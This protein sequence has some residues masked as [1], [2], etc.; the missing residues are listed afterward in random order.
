MNISEHV[1]E[2]KFKNG[3]YDC[4]TGNADFYHFLGKKRLYTSFDGLIT[5]TSLAVLEKVVAKRFYQKPFI[6]EVCNEDGTTGVMVCR[7]SEPKEPGCTLIRMKELD[8]IFEDYLTAKMRQREAD[9]LL[10]LHDCIYYSYD[11]LTDT[12]ICY[13]CD[14]ERE[15]L[16]SLKLDQWLKKAAARL[17]KISHGEVRKFADALIGGTRNFTGSFSV[18]AKSSVIF[19]GAAIYDD[20]IHIKTVGAFEDSN[21]AP[22]HKS[23]HKDQLT[24]LF[25]KED[26]NNYAKRLIGDLK[27]STTLAI[28]DIDDFKYVNDHHGH[29][30]G[31]AVLKKC[32]SIIENE[33]GAY[34][35]AGRIGGDEFLVVFDKIPDNETLRYVLRAIKNNIASAYSDEKDGFHVTTSIGASTYPADASDFDSLFHLT[36]YMLYRAK[37]KGKNRYIIYEPEKHGFVEDILNSSIETTG[38]FGRKGMNKADVV[39][40]IADQ[41]L[42]GKEYPAD[43]IIR[44]IVEHFG[45]ERVILY[46]KT[47]QTALQYGARL[48]DDSVITETKDYIYD[49]G[50]LDHYK[51]GVMVINNVETF[52]LKTPGLYEKLRRQEIYSLMHREITGKS[53]KRFLLSCES[54]SAYLTWNQ[55]DMH[56]YRILDYVL[57]SVL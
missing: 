20:D 28:I 8:E 39:C 48:L 42:R 51:D 1:I 38:I 34:G 36:D 53:G 50:L 52:A 23:A 2:A 57:S 29:S 37:H 30:M 17:P 24:G 14:D 13:R 49:V 9:V 5:D 27:Q 33:A 6:L 26:I 43:N 3:S 40:R 55:E 32:A 15:T 56:F 31:D 16:C 41:L 45:V 19:T 12:M 46:D 11:C 4:I 47:A 7:I 10:S 44:D 25:L 21:T 18:D 35:K 54:V 22:M